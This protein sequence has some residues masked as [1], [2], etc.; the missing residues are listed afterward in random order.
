MTARLAPREPRRRRDDRTPATARL[1]AIAELPHHTGLLHAPTEERIAY[2]EVV[3]GCLCL[4]SLIQQCERTG[5]RDEKGGAEPV[6]LVLTLA[7]PEAV[8]IGID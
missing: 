6:R 1:G 5:A 3:R 4:H 7:V 8:A 2:A